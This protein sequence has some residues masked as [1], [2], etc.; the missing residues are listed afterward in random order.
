DGPVHSS[1]NERGAI[2][3]DEIVLSDAAHPEKQGNFHEA[4]LGGPGSSEFARSWDWTGI[5]SRGS[6]SPII[7]VREKLVGD[8]IA[9]ANRKL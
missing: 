2:L 7:I 6:T 1:H 3:P 4:V 8:A 9:E 5:A